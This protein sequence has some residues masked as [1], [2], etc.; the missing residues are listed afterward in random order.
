MLTASFSYFV[1][2]FHICIAPFVLPTSI[3][4]KYALGWMRT[5]N[6][7]P[8]S[9]LI[10]VTFSTNIRELYCKYIILDTLIRST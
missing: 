2:K 7:K 9:S 8:E 3:L 5:A 10:S 4:F 6:R 1:R